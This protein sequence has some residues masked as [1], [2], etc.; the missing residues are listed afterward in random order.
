MIPIGRVLSA[1]G[2][3]GEVGFKYYNASTEDF[4]RY[5]SFITEV[6]GKS[7]VLYLKVS[8]SERVS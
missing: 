1:H 2:V 4:Y 8:G 7:M 5:T 6:D 3:Q